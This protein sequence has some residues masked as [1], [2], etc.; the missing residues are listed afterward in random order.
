MVKAFGWLQSATGSN[1]EA[2]PVLH[3]ALDCLVGLHELFL[4]LHIDV[5]QVRVVYEEDRRQS[6]SDVRYWGHKLRA[7]S[8]LAVRPQYSNADHTP[9]RWRCSVTLT[10]TLSLNVYRGTCEVLGVAKGRPQKEFHLL[11]CLEHRRYGCVSNSKRLKDQRR[12][13]VS[14]S[15]VAVRCVD[16]GYCGWNSELPHD[17]IEKRLGKGAVICH[18]V[19]LT[20]DLLRHQLVLPCIVEHSFSVNYLIARVEIRLH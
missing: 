12:H 10:Q 3:T 13:R 4:P 14:H 17:I 8:F 9:T 11:Y 2:T 16:G 7:M 6:G 18:A 1:Q 20:K 19:L 5:N 15:V